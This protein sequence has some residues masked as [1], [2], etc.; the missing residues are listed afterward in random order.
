M[1]D[2]CISNICW[3]E[4]PISFLEFCKSND[5]S[6]IEVAPTK[7]ISSIYQ[8]DRSALL[9]FLHEA[10]RRSISIESM[11]SLFYQSESNIFL[12]E[13]MFITH[14][15][16]I[17]DVATILECNYLVFGSPKNRKKP[18]IMSTEE[19]KDIFC[20]IMKRISNIM[21]NEYQE[22]KF[23]LEANPK[24]YGC[25]FITN[26]LEAKEILDKIQK[27]NIVFHLDTACNF[28]AQKDFE[29]AFLENKKYIHKIHISEPYLNPIKN[30]SIDIEKIFKTL[31]K[32][33]F[34]GTVSIEMK[35]ARKE[36]ILDS[37]KFVKK[38][39]KDNMYG[40]KL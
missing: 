18:D 22:I 6:K 11:Q 27:Q 1:I 2:L 34:E 16:N 25:N 7:I 21:K 17:F 24:E 10:K 26:Y 8:E 33:D 15:K 35:Q 39:I 38:I 32:H 19:A 40:K 29:K 23:A 12:N 20:K 5:I 14:L 13:D 3:D 4:D 36:D 28:M 31:Y 30:N 9:Y 37:L